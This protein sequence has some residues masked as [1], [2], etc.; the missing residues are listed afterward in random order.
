[1]LKKIIRARSTAVRRLELEPIA[2]LLRIRT[3]IWISLLMNALA[4]GSVARPQ[5]VEN[6][7]AE[8]VGVDT[9]I[10]C[11]RIWTGDPN[12]PWAE[13]LA[14]EDGLIRAV[15]SREEIEDL[16]GSGTEVIDASNGFA[17]PGL[18]DAHVHLYSLGALTEEVDL[19]DVGSVDEA[20]DRV[21]E[22][23]GQVPAGTWILGRN[24][25]QSLWA[26][27]AFPTAAQLDA[28]VPDHPVWLRRVDGHAAW[29]NSEAMRRAGIS[30]TTEVDEGGQIIRDEDGQPT[31]V[32]IDEA[33][34][35]VGRAVPEPDQQAIERRLLA[36]QE[37]CLRLGLTGVHDAALDGDMI[38]VLRALDKQG[39]LRLRVYGMARP[40]EDREVAY[41]SQPPPP[42]RPDARFEL[43]AIKLFIDGAMGSRGAL[44]FEPYDDDPH[45]HGLLL[46][47]EETLRQTVVQALQSGWQVCTHAIGDRGNAIVL[48]AYLD[49][50]CAVPEA[51]DPRLRIEHA[52]VIRRE[53]VP[54]F[55]EGGIVASMQPSHASTDKRWA[56]LRLGENTSRVA[57]AYAWR[58]FARE[59]VPLAFGSDFP[60][61]EPSPFWGIYAALTR[62][63]RSLEPP[64]GWHPEHLLSLDETLRGFTAGAAYA[65]FAEDRRG[66]I[67]PGM[68][69]DLT[70]I[71]RD[72]FLVEPK[73]IL[74]TR[75]LATIVAGETVY[76]AEARADNE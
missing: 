31:G 27:R 2:A 58:W 41:V 38:D 76:R 45:N 28:R 60:V 30:L 75:V 64:G 32:F 1:M 66:V 19:R 55:V 16:G 65:G 17:M 47:P 43:R 52:Q 67:R 7:D 6:M 68:E 48:D 5:G 69:A 51:S 72:L 42:S 49:G 23:A 14:I 70:L 21:A 4:S 40:P 63:D 12:H 73:A 22:R 59:G 53:D 18:I 62:R 61:E 11:S 3:I 10:V 50:R 54:R 20:V 34:G 56:D 29:A 25:D 9:I 57:G 44:V 46:M 13:A 15:G 24:W 71:D 8:G 33:M 37:E 36:A 26:G 39:R 74:E 35:L